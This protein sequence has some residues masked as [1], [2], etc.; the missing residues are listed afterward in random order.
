M[1][2]HA[3]GICREEILRGL[4]RQRYKCKPRERTSDDTYAVQRLHVYKKIYFDVML[5]TPENAFSVHER[6]ISDTL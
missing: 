5:V 6:N 3:G 1:G 4:Q 2:K